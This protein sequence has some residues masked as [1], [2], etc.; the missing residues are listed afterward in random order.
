MRK[1]KEETYNDPWERDFYET[2]STRPP[3]SYGGIVAVLLIAVILLGGI[4]SA[5]GVLNIKLIRQLAS[6]QEAVES[7]TLFENE[8]AAPDEM[9]ATVPVAQE[10][11]FPALGIRGQTVSDFDRR[12]YRMPRG[13][14]VTEVLTETEQI[15]VGDVIV[16]L[17]EL[18]LENQTE[19]ATALADYE[20]G[21]PAVLKVYRQ[22]TGEEF[23]VNV[24]IMEE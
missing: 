4:C 19:L 20:N 18:A 13:V 6:M 7:V 17:D 1:R 24:N 15:R 9:N 2:G 16:S 8:T 5:L 21:A 23:L 22:C 11:D 12:F 10:Q 14:L 3:K